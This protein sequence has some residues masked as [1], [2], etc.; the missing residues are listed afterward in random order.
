VVHAG[1]DSIQVSIPMDRLVKHW[2]IVDDFKKGLSLRGLA[3]RHEYPINKIIHVLQMYECIPKLEPKPD[4][5]VHLV[6][7]DQEV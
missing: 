6:Q 3:I 4:E 1:K 5:K 2:E 7:V